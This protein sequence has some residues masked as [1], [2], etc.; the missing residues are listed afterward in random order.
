MSLDKQDLSIKCATCGKDLNEPGQWL[1]CRA[2]FAKRIKEAEEL[3]QEWRN[4][5]FFADKVEWQEWVNDFG[6]RVD[7]FLEGE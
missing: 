7:S 4:T 1:R 6:A 3:L 2:H 5:P